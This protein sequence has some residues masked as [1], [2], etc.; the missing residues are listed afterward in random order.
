M[1]LLV[2]VRSAEEVAAALAGG[3]D[4]VDA[5]EPARGSLGAVTAAVLSAIAARTP[6]WVPLSVALG[7][8]AGLDGLRVSMDAARIAER[9][10]PVY[11]K[12]GFAGT[13]S[14]ER[15][16]ALLQSAVATAGPDGIV[17]VAYADHVAA[18]TLSPEDVLRAAVAAGARG[19][20]VDTWRKDGARC[21]ITSRSSAS[22]RCPWLPVPPACSSPWL[23]VSTAMPSR[24]WPGSRTSSASAG[25]PV[26]AG[27][28]A[29]WMPGEWPS[30]GGASARRRHRS[31]SGER[32][33]SSG[34]PRVNGRTRRPPLGD[35]SPN[36]STD[37]RTTICDPG[38][39]GISIAP[40]R[41]PS[42]LS[43]M[44]PSR[45]PGPLRSRFGRRLLLL[46][47]GST[48]LPT[49]VVATL[50]YRQV[51]RYLVAQSETSLHQASK[52]FGAAVFE[53]LLMADATLKNVAASP[54]LPHA[55]QPQHRRIRRRW[56]RPPRGGLPRS[57]S[58][59][60]MD[61]VC[62]SSGG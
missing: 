54:A 37:C 35:P 60:G 53:R 7:D 31:R 38:P 36:A 43:P 40:R 20:L 15:I 46:F 8:C 34:L 21:S 49:A 55:L 26:A 30:C 24:A 45:H 48:V 3:A 16:T 11:V 42:P 9:R 23:A 1:R 27:G 39:E 59:C 61:A 57:N 29:K 50:S 5:K 33:F 13:R 22:P 47:V 4:I 17:A 56:T 14:L 62:R 10:A 19:F 51:T 32:P 44:N 12:L 25:R 6:A 41:G 18:G 28:P 58:S 52:A 2:S